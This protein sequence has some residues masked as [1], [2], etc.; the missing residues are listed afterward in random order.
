LE[1][2]GCA[3]LEE[4]AET[5]RKL[6]WA[7]HYQ[8]YQAGALRRKTARKEQ[9]SSAWQEYLARSGKRRMEEI[10]SRLMRLTKRFKVA[11]PGFA[12]EWLHP[13]MRRTGLSYW[14]RKEA[15]VRLHPLVADDAVP[16]EVVEYEIAYWIALH[17]V[18]ISWQQIQAEISQAGL[19]EVARKAIAWRSRS[20][21]RFLRGHR[22]V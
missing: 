22:I 13:S 14:F 4:Q 3:H 10:E 9:L 16:W 11:D 5:W 19:N 18:G 17:V 20:W 21:P 12:L 2:R 8:K 6:H 7:A 1:R 15:V